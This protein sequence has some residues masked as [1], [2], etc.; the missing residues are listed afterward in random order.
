VHSWKDGDVPTFFL[1]KTALLSA[2]TILP[3][4]WLPLIWGEKGE[5]E[6]EV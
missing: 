2:E 5:A 6:R 4:G 1:D 3:R